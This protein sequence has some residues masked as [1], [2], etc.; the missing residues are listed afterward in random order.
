[1]YPCWSLG[2]AAGSRQMGG[3]DGGGDGGGSG[4]GGEGGVGGVEGAADGGSGSGGEAGGD[5]GGE[6]QEPVPPLNTCAKTLFTFLLISPP[7]R[8]A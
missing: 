8:V 4:G 2:E 6:R 7:A 5:G 1:M 3:A